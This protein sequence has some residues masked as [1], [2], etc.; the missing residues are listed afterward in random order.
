VETDWKKPPSNRRRKSNDW[1]WVPYRSRAELKMSR[2]DDGTVL[3]PSSVYSVGGGAEVSGGTREHDNRVQR[4]GVVRGGEKS[5]N[6]GVRW[7]RGGLVGRESTTRTRT[8]TH[9]SE[10]VLHLYVHRERVTTVKLVR[11]VCCTHC[12][13]TLSTVARDGCRRPGPLAL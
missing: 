5:T 3:S 6:I 2:I 8:R 1:L 12:G 13:G 11:C 7:V 4:D 10:R 9:A